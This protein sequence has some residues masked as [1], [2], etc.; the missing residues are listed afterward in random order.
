[1]V[2]RTIGGV[3][4]KE[5]E[6]GAHS[7]KNKSLLSECNI[8]WERIQRQKIHPYKKAL[9]NSVEQTFPSKELQINDLAPP[10]SAR[11]ELPLQ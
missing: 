1:M 5:R 6:Q 10:T 2:N 4:E 9:K 8:Y 7:F 11:G 3:C